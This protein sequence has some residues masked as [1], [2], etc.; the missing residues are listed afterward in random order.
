MHGTRRPLIA[1]NWKMNHTQ[2]EVPEYLQV[3]RQELP[4]QAAEQGDVALLPPFTALPA[5]QAALERERD[6]AGTMLHG[7]QDL[8]VAPKGAFTG[9][10]SGPMLR[11]LGCSLVLVGHSERRLHHLETDNTVQAKVRAAL[12][13]GLT[14]VLCVG[15]G[16]E[17][18]EAGGHVEFTIKQVAEALDGLTAQDAAPLVCAYEPVWAIGTGAVATPEDAQEV[19]AAIREQLQTTFTKQV[20][21]DTRVI[22]GGSVTVSNT[23]QLMAQ[24]DIDGALV[25]GAS[26]DPRTLAGICRAALSN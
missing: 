23:S 18:R 6:T 21:D 3:L 10:V 25:G 5:M 8:A 26:L 24:P 13:A 22:Y 2:K 1:G 12:D 11:A 19:C 17:V 4:A 14:P 20:A 9:D 16:L 15:E 7:A